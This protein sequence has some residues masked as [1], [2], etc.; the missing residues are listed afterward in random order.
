MAL[1]CCNLKRASQP[2]HL[3]HVNG[4]PG[5]THQKTHGF[6]SQPFHKHASI[7]EIKINGRITCFMHGQAWLEWLVCRLSSGNFQSRLNWV[8]SQYDGCK[9]Y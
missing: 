4:L 6:R 7:N 3:T 8:F 9:F 2:N 1:S 5:A